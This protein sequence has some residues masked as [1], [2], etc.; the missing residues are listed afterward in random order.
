MYMSI[1][2]TDCVLYA[3]DKGLRPASVAIDSAIYLLTISL[4]NI[5][6]I[7]MSFYDIMYMSVCV[8]PACLEYQD[9]L[10]MLTTYV[11]CST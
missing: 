3:V 8:H 6:N 10:G 9:A 4:P 2:R 11:R 7:A 5:H 1:R